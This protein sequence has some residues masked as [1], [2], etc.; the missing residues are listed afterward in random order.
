ML[1]CDDWTGTFHEYEFET[2]NKLSRPSVTTKYI[3]R[4]NCI[5]VQSGYIFTNV[6][7][8]TTKHISTYIN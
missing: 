3:P 2:Q 8:A 1:K 5:L 6:I 7:F 4:T